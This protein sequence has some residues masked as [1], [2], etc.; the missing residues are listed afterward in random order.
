[1][2]YVENNTNNNDNKQKRKQK[3]IWFNLP[4]SK[5]IKTHIGKIFLQLLSKY[6]PKNHRM[7]KIYNRNT[8][9][10]S[11]SYM[12]NIASIILAHTRNI[13]NPIV[14]S[15]RCNCRVK[16]SSPLNGE[17]LTWKIIYRADVS[18][19]KNSNK[20][21]YFGLAD[22]PFKE[23]YRNHTKDFK[24]EK[25]E[26][27]TELVKYIWQSKRGNINFSIKYSIVSKVSGNPSSIICPL[28]I[29]E[30]LWIIKFLKNKDLLSKKSELIN[31][32]RHL[33]KNLS[34]NVKNR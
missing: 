33:K 12:T 11:Y 14:Q 2:H 4:F 21:F 19:D 25:Y 5:S 8:V 15:F 24:H 3:N 29:A 20:K 17:C 10:T 9:K 30:K 1:M 34:A 7:Y 16:S 27:C 23:R 18:N 6:F 26:N 28:C 22:T 13:L 31:K 32:C